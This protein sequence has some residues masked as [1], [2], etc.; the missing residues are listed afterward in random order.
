M[1]GEKCT[2]CDV[3]SL[4]DRLIGE[5][6]HAFAILSSPRLARGHTLVVPRQHVERPSALSRIEKLAMQ[7]LTDRLHDGILD[8]GIAWGVDT[9]QKS[10]PLEPWG[11]TET[12]HLR[13]DLVPSLPGGIIYSTALQWDRSHYQEL[14]DVERIAMV[15]LLGGLVVP[16]SE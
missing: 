4:E 3:S 5:N 11:R 6:E 13:T 16:E 7:E 15:R 8:A 14:Q 12:E 10:R 2:F 1:A 9:W